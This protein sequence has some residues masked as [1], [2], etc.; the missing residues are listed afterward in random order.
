MTILSKNPVVNIIP[1]NNNGTFTFT[2]RGFTEVADSSGTGIKNI[3]VYVWDGVDSDLPI[4][5]IQGTDFSVTQLANESG[6]IR[7]LN[8]RTIPS[9]QFVIIYSDVPYTQEI[10]FPTN[11]PV[12][13]SAVEIMGDRLEMQIKQ[14]LELYRTTAHIAFPP[15]HPDFELTVAEPF[16]E[17][18]PIVFE[19][20]S[21]NSWKM[22]TTQFTI[23]DFQKLA[24]DAQ[25]GATD[26]AAS[27]LDAKNSEMQSSQHAVNSGAS[28]VSANLSAAAAQQEYQKT[29]QL[30]VDVELVKV[31]VESLKNA[32]DLNKAGTDADKTATEAARAATEQLK[33]DVIV[34]VAKIPDPTGQPADQTILT[35][36][37]NSWKF[38]DIPIVKNLDTAPIGSSVIV[39]EDPVTGK[40]SLFAGS[41]SMTTTR[42]VGTIRPGI[43]GGVTTETA[44]VS[45][46][47]RLQA[48]EG[49]GT[50]FPWGTANGSTDFVVDLDADLVS[51]IGD[52]IIAPN[53]TR[54]AKV[55]DLGIT[56]FF[57]TGSIYT[58][59]AVISG[60]TMLTAPF[61]LI[62]GMYIDGNT[63]VPTVILS[64][65][66]PGT[67][68][69]IQYVATGIELSLGAEKIVW[70]VVLNEYLLYSITFDGSQ[71]S[72]FRTRINQGN[73]E[74]I[75]LT[76]L[77]ITGT[78][79]STG[80]VVSASTD[81]R[82]YRVTYI[83]SIATAQEVNNFTRSILNP[84][85]SAGHPIL[86]GNTPQGFTT[87]GVTDLGTVT[88][89]GLYPF[90]IVKDSTTNTFSTKLLG[91]G[92]PLLFTNVPAGKTLNQNADFSTLGTSNLYSIVVV[93]DPVTGNL[94]VKL[95]PEVRYTKTPAT[96]KYPSLS[97]TTPQLIGTA[98]INNGEIYIENRTDKDIYISDSLAELTADPTLGI[99][100]PSNA[101]LKTNWTTDV[102]A[103]TGGGTDATGDVVV[104]ITKLA[105]A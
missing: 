39:V 82:I 83:N 66:G 94:E 30:K 59:P 27:A 48:L 77:P 86:L 14:L 26:A 101:A 62:L 43:E 5:Q 16:V 63:P 58:M 1:G 90:A 102:Y 69:K 78:L 17:N 36:G 80:F 28:A 22:A 67:L 105:V 79:R 93:R 31:Q 3:Q 50:R 40:S 24:Q 64:Q 10:S 98:D 19:R 57:S 8:S 76:A 89:D 23:P 21:A 75:A 54:D 70:P 35:D 56:Q 34:I 33:Q 32:T 97:A 91:P 87:T 92:T 88:T 2:F 68:L 4:Q 100:I 73:V 11:Q 46:E 37:A 96:V 103:V 52:N 55:E 85:G 61:T 60:T 49:S 41:N 47:A 13:P 15:T 7:F 44:L 99:K 65:T 25:K 18:S 53:N 29:A 84:V 104:T 81:L 74:N 38:G 51:T 6:Q 9:G 71:F 72:G 45:H 12:N 20:V 42:Q 95:M